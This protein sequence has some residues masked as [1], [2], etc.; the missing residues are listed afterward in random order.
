VTL[1]DYSVRVLGAASFAVVVGFGAP[2]QADVSS[3]AYAGGGASQLT[4]A[5]GGDGS[6]GLLQLDAGIGTSPEYPVVVGAMFRM[7]THFGEGTDWALLERTATHGFVNGTWGAAL[8]LG[9]YKRW[10]E[11]S[12]TGFMASLNGGLP[13]GIN[14][15][16]SLGIAKDSERTF[17]V[18]LG[19]DWA[20]M[21]AYRT[22]GE[23][24]WPNYRLPLRE[25]H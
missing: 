22:T 15:S 2:A 20:R 24:W 1:R 13:W 9:A 7:M 25:E 19:I 17:A 14:L 4:H 18:T 3:W 21:T 12:S 5:D 11:P 10:W 16:A 8:D 6:R 23:S